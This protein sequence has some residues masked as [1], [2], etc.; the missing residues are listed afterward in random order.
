MC[1][2]AAVKGESQNCESPD[3]KGTGAQLRSTRAA[4]GPIG[5][6]RPHKCCASGRPGAPGLPAWL[7]GATCCTRPAGGLPPTLRCVRPL[8]FR[9]FSV[10][11][12]CTL[13]APQY[14][15]H[16]A[17][18]RPA[19]RSSELQVCLP[20]LSL[21]GSLMHTLVSCQHQLL[22]APRPLPVAAP[23]T[24]PQPPPSPPRG[25]TQHRQAQLCMSPSS[26]A[27]PSSSLYMYS[28]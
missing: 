11:P 23:S 13:N 14:L 27:G 2:V 24:A 9:L 15:C 7:P 6:G 8:S 12:M 16:P 21:P 5:Q 19:N 22:D 20:C 1:F 4:C 10:T 26:S 17:A 25:C 18:S 3:Q 28:V